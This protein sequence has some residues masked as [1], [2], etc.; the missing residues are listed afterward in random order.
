MPS[1]GLSRNGCTSSPTTSASICVRPRLST[2]DAAF[3]VRRSTKDVGRAAEGSRPSTRMRPPWRASSRVSRSPSATRHRFVVA[4]STG[5]MVWSGRRHGYSFNTAVKENNPWPLH[6]DTS[7]FRYAAPLLLHLTTDFFLGCLGF[8]LEF[9]NQKVNF[10]I[11]ENWTSRR[12]AS[13]L[14]AAPI[15]KGGNT[16]RRN[17]GRR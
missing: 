13:L 7:P 9:K 12:F 14:S 3:L 15:A 4:A 1:E 10:S 16:K 6:C 5:C 8:L 11:G 17:Q 2:A